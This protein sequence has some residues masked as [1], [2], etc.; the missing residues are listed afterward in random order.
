MKTKIIMCMTLL[1]GIMMTAGCD[2]VCE[3]CNCGTKNCICRGSANFSRAVTSSSIK[4]KNGETIILSLQEK[5]SSNTETSSVLGC[6]K[7]SSDTIFTA[8]YFI[9][10][11]VI[12][13]SADK[14][15]NFSVSAVLENL[16]KG[17]HEI[18]AIISTNYNCIII[19][20]TITPC[21][22][23]VE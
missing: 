4:I 3:G 12:A 17:E 10:G 14:G 15:N 21:K 13:K 23:A 19:T 11:H 1:I 20:Q 7:C 22:V 6:D 2:D 5:D 8:T 16:A 9:D 18:T